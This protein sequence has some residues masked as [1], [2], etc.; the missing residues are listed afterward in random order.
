MLTD[1]FT[2]NPQPSSMQPD[3]IR[4]PHKTEVLIT[5]AIPEELVAKL[6]DI[7]PRLTFTVIPASKIED[8]PNDVWER[9]EVLYTNRVIPTPVQAPSLRWIQFHWAGIE[10][11]LDEPLLRKP[12]LLATSLS[13]AAASQMAEYV[14]TMML[15]LGH[16]LPDMIAHQKRAD[17]PRDRWERFSPLEL[18]DSTVGIVGYGSIGRQVARLLQPFGIHILAT[19]KDAMNPKDIGYIP[20]GMG[21]P[22]GDLVHRLYPPEALCSMIKECDFLVVTTPKTPDT[23]NMIGAAEIAALKPTAFLIDVSR[24]GIVDHKALISSLKERQIAGAALD[25]YPEEPLPNDSPLW[26][27]S[28]VV[29][30][31]HISGNTLHYDERAMELFAENLGRYINHLPLF[32]LIDLER[33]Y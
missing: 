5:M 4:I 21:D 18:R 14:V 1:D 23:I 25:V 20:D 29:L 30:S 17:W 32:N 28:E 13:G 15:A 11:A 10:H 16:R 33:G 31:P 8:I 6:R 2:P 24:G 26:K 27:L 19:K 7:S 3:P 12:S 9:S 22:N